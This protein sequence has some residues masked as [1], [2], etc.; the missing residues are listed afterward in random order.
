MN[1]TT[2]RSFRLDKQLSEI[3]DK[4]SDRMGI[5]VNALVNI[6]IKN[7]SEFYR[8]LS[9]I[10]MIII[11][12]MILD[13]L[14]ALNDEDVNALIADLEGIA[15][16]DIHKDKS[17]IYVVGGSKKHRIGTAG[18]IFSL[19]ADNGVNIDMIS[20]CYAEISIGFIVDQEIAEKA[21][22]VLH[23]ELVEK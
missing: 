11:H 18:K 7:Y 3:L 10:D 20:A 21:V 14:I 17:I 8:F 16:T 13:E 19:M 22:K 1:T 12:K 23:T 15:H 4:E 2:T 5:S 9:R 6:I